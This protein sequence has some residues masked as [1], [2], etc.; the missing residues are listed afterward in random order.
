MMP[1]IPQNS[2]LKPLP[3]KQSTHPN[4]K[5]GIWA[6]WRDASIFMLPLSP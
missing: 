5:G 3:S 2:K 4:E 6:I 1:K